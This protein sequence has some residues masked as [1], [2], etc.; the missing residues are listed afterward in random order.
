MHSEPVFLNVY[1]AQESIPR[2]EFRQ[3]CSLAGRYDNPIPTRFLA[4]I[5]SLKI[6][7]LYS[8]CVLYVYSKVSASAGHMAWKVVMHAI[9]NQSVSYFESFRHAKLLI[10]HHKCQRF[11]VSKVG[12]GGCSFHSHANCHAEPVVMN[13]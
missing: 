6:P 5:D 8:K 9:Y 13:S 10:S 2:N 7:A 3:L 4:P 12:R 1:G 11:L